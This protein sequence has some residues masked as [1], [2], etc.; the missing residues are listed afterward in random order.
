MKQKI[1]KHLP[2]IL[3]ILGTLTYI[4][5]FS[6]FS[7][8]RYEK[9]YSHYFDLGIMNQAAYNSYQAVK[10][11]DMGR[12]LEITDP[13]AAT[14]QVKRMAVHN[15]PFLALAGM[16]YFIH[17]GPATLLVLQAVVVA[18]GALI[19][20]ALTCAVLNNNHHSAWLGMLL[21]YT[22]L[23]YPPLQR[24]VAFDFHAITLS[25]TF[26]LAWYYF[27][28]RK[29]YI[30]SSF[31]FLLALTTKENVPL[32][33]G[34]FSALLL[35]QEMKNRPALY[36]IKQPLNMLKNVFMHRKNRYLL[37]WGML[38]VVWLVV[39]M[40]VIIPRAEGGSHFGSS[41]YSYILAR[42][43]DVPF[44]ALRSNARE[45]VFSLLAPVSFLPLISPFFA[46]ALV[47]DLLVKILSTNENLINTYF[48]YDALLTGFIFIATV[49]G[50]KRIVA[51]FPDM[52]AKFPQRINR[53]IQ[54]MNVH[55]MEKTAIDKRMLSVSVIV[56]I[57]TILCSIKYSALPFARRPELHPF[58]PAPAKY[59]DV[60]YWKNKLKS[61]SLIVSTTGS[62]AP[63]FTSRRMYLDF[64]MDYNVAD[65]VVIDTWDA[66]HGFLKNDSKPAYDLIRIDPEFE[67]IY[68]NDGIE[69][70]KRVKKS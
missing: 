42:P 23:F 53:I 33:T 43:W 32:S 62:M 3:L 68:D 7:I 13:H 49:Q 34:F 55:T 45:F 15:D 16:F 10:T 11:G 64:A 22:Y 19:V 24:A 57:V 39:T 38:S 14:R 29:R 51:D 36:S 27:F 58:A 69:V 5:Y 8:N 12:M 1:L 6:L 18:L 20:Y 44:F 60:I 35:L 48:H 17:E 59:D 52:F 28:I 25:V 54:V 41:Y 70:Y 26:I 30:I 67:R 47:P 56:V 50:V 61:D 9:N 2:F 31:F 46:L 21:G 37:L 40:A 65:Y 63:F 4:I 66:E